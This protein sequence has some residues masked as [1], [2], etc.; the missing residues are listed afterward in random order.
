MRYA[1]HLLAPLPGARLIAVSRRDEASGRG[2]AEANDLRFYPDAEKLIAD[3]DVEAVIVVTPPAFSPALCL[4]AVRARKPILIEKPLACTALEA[5]HMAEAAEAA[6]VPLMTAQTLRFDETIQA[7]KRET[8]GLGPLRYIVLTARMEADRFV[9]KV[10][11]EYGG[12]GLL[13]EIGVHLFDLIRFVT[14]EE[15]GDVRCGIERGN[16]GQETRVLAEIRTT[17]GHPCLVDLSRVSAVRVCRVEW[18]ADGGQL[19]ADWSRSHLV[20]ALPGQPL[21]ERTFP[22]SATIVA[23]LTAFLEGLE[24]HAPMPVTGRDGQKAVEA[25]DACYASA[26]TGQPVRLAGFG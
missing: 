6:G 4:A 25:V 12:R 21:E 11:A 24:R 10:P 9:G 26:L 3:P 17:G 23:T 2:F 5:A 1:R 7:L 14:G 19:L 16:S 18:V 15:I 13:L 20:C 22:P 8:P